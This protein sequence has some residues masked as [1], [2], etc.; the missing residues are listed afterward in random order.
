[1]ILGVV[2]F[3]FLFFVFYFFGLCTLYPIRHIET[4]TPLEYIPPQYQPHHRIT[5]SQ[6]IISTGYPHL[7]HRLSTGLSM[8]YQ[9]VIHRYTSCSRYTPGGMYLGTNVL[10]WGSSGMRWDTVGCVTGVGVSLVVVIRG[11]GYWGEHVTN[12]YKPIPTPKSTPP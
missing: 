2:P 5:P 7:M 1:M 8:D 12:R 11:G 10:G 4:P 3:C 6:Y 9:L